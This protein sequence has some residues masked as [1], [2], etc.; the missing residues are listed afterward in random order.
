MPPLVVISNE[1]TY[2][3][4]SNTV[5]LVLTHATAL[6]PAADAK[7]LSWQN[8][9]TQSEDEANIRRREER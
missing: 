3:I 2:F 5:E 6:T 1:V 9:K 7:G 4:Q 8:S